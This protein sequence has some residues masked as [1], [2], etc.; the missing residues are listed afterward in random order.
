VRPY[1]IIFKYKSASPRDHI[2]DFTNLV[3]FGPMTLNGIALIAKQIIFHCRPR[4]IAPSYN[5]FLAQLK[6]IVKIKEFLPKQKK[7]YICVLKNGNIF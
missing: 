3:M 1:R 6:N 7:N 2:I 5:I 4:N